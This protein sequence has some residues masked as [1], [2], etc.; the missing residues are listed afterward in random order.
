MLELTT[1]CWF[2]RVRY[3]FHVSTGYN[4]SYVNGFTLLS[5]P[6]MLSLRGSWLS[7]REMADLLAD[8]SPII[9]RRQVRKFLAT[10][11]SIAWH[12]RDAIS[13]SQYKNK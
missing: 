4:V 1:P 2:V 6:L 7:G 9:D 12:V 13:E 8:M 11:L 5:V 10:R 3:A